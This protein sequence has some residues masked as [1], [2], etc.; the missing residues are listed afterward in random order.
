MKGVMAGLSD[1]YAILRV[2]PQ[3]FTSKHVDNTDSPK[4]GE[5]YE[6]IRMESFIVNLCHHFTGVGRLRIICHFTIVL[7]LRDCYSS[8]GM[9]IFI[10]G[11]M[12]QSSCPCV[13]P[14]HQVIVHEVPGQELEVEVYD[15]DP[16]QDDFLGRYI[17]IF[18]SL[19]CL[20]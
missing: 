8:V 4:W 20:R 17:C 14:V 15:K 19:V 6:V 5:I 9:F 11:R 13:C 2:G 10:H 1:P 18:M 7:Y 3:T 12:S 16:D